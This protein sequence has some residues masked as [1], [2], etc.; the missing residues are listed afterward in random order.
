MADIIN[1][2]TENADILWYIDSVHV[3]KEKNKIQVEGW[4]LSQTGEVKDILINGK[5]LKPKF[6][7][8]SDVDDIYDCR[9]L[10]SGFKLEFNIE[11]TYE[12]V[13]VKLKKD[14]IDLINIGSFAKWIAFYSKFK[15]IDKGVIVVDD[16][17]GDPDFIREWVIR[18]I[19]FSPSNYHKGERATSKFFVDGT[20]EV[21][22]QIIGKPIYNWNHERYANGIFQFC[23]ADQPIVYHVDN[24]TYAG[25]VFLTPDAPLNTGTS[26]YRSKETGDFKFDDEKRSTESY[27]RAFKGKSAEMN[28]YDGTN[29]EKIDEVGNKYNRLVLFDAKNIHAATQYF[30]DAIDNSRLFHMFFFDV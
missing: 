20:K 25:I 10:N 19:E 8:R 9:G 6:S 4:I 5:S 24:Q 27:V 1:Q 17:Y 21:L 14:P 22:E 23:T 11:D 2:I 18:D 12:A 7:F 29:F 26:F 13:Q 3:L 15:S 30:G 16:F 28:F